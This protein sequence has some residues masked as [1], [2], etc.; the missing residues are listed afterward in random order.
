MNYEQCTDSFTVH[1][2]SCSLN[3]RGLRKLIDGQGFKLYSQ[4]NEIIRF[5]ET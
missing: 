3:I 4:F 1:V 5:C 2:S